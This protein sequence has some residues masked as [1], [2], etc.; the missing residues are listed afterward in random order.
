MTSLDATIVNVALPD[1]RSDLGYLQVSVSDLQWVVNAYALTYASAL[2][3]AGKLGDIF[4][5]RR[6]FL[7][8][9]VVF[10][11]SSIGSGP[12]REWVRR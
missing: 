11:A 1:I 12:F 9:L 6:V 3:T 8:G 5:R 10:T 7:L 2:L 4:G